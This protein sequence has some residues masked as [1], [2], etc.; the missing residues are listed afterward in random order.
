MA[1]K[2]HGYAHINDYIL[3]NFQVLFMKITGSQQRCYLVNIGQDI[4]L[5]KNDAI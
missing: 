5:W 4:F 3:T 1:L 2:M